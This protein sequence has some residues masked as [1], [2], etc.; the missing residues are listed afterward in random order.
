MR[1]IKI[2][3]LINTFNNL[4]PNDFVIITLKLCC[5]N[6][7]L[8]TILGFTL[9]LIGGIGLILSLVGLSLTFLAPI[10][11]IG[12]GAAFLIKIIMM[13]AGIIIVYIVKTS[14]GND[15]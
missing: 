2:D 9:F 13:L 4:N 6:K 15:E 10:E 8:I 11:S 1:K 14:N 3:D 12:A 5:M 7:S